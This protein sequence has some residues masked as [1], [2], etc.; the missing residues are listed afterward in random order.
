MIQIATTCHVVAY[1]EV[2]TILA[3]FT[4]VVIVT[5]TTFKLVTKNTL[6]QSKSQ[7]TQ[8]EPQLSWYFW[9]NFWTCKWLPV[10]KGYCFLKNSPSFIFHISVILLH[11][12]NCELP[13][14]AITVSHNCY[15]FLVT[16]IWIVRLFLIKWKMSTPYSRKDKWRCGLQ[17]MKS[18][19]NL[20][21]ELDL[22]PTPWFTQ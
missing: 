18:I 21:R 2:I 15:N 3:M 8:L 5:Q 19:L 20:P 13:Y 14:G 1:L 11:C 22:I 16:M 9:N 17:W 7:L 10:I 4:I 12:G 6:V